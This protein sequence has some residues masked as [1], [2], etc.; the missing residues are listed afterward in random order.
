LNMEV[1]HEPRHCFRMKL[2]G[3]NQKS[4]SMQYATGELITYYRSIDA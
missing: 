2:G 3:A 1:N 4:L